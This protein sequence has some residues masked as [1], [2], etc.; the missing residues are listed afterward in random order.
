[1]GTWEHG[2]IEISESGIA[3]M[4]KCRDMEVWKCGKS[5][6]RRDVETV[7]DLLGI[8]SPPKPQPQPTLNPT[9]DDS[10]P[11]TIPPIAP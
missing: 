8:A 5:K 6:L 2:N 1:M 7:I 10:R 4:W 11:T 3:A 9:K